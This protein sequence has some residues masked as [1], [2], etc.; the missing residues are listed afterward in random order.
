LLNVKY[1]S[2]IPSKH[3]HKAGPILRE[4]LFPM[5]R[6]SKVLDGTAGFLMVSGAIQI[7]RFT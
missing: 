7:N 6:E 1:A 2:G 5:L 4:F 3:A